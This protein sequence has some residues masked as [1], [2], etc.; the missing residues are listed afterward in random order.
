VWPPRGRVLVIFAGTAAPG[1][2]G[3][4]LRAVDRL[5]PAAS[6]LVAATALNQVRL[7]DLGQPGLSGLQGP[8]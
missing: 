7:P 1:R 3:S 2:T 8:V 4:R 5:Y 6:G